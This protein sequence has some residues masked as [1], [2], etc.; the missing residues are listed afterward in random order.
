MHLR[1]ATGAEKVAG[2]RVRC[3]F[4]TVIFRAD[5]SKAEGM[6]ANLLRFSAGLATLL[7]Q[8]LALH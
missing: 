7:I 3:S 1:W 5:T 6:E 2:L 4:A 8:V